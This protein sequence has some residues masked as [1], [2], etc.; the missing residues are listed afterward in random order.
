MTWPTP[1][2][3]NESIQNPQFNFT[4][5]ELKSGQVLLNDFGLPQVASG[6]FASVYR[7]K[8]ESRD[9]AVRCFLKDTPDQQKR[10][11][12]ISEFLNASKLPYV[13][14]FDYLRRGILVSGQ[15]LPILKMEWVQG[16]PLDVHVKNHARESE[17]LRKLA[18][19]IRAMV[20]ALHDC[21]IAHGDLQHGNI[22]ASD[23]AQCKLVDYDG[24]FVPSLRG[25]SS[26]E[27]GHRNYQHPARDNSHFDDRLD[28]FSAWSIITALNCIAEDP[29][30]IDNQGACDES[31]LF[32]QTDYRYPLRSLTFF[33][34][35]SHNS[36]VVRDSA[37]SLRSLLDRKI[38]EIPFL[39]EK[40]VVPQNLPVLASVFTPLP[41]APASVKAPQ[42][43]VEPQSRRQGD[44][45]AEE[46]YPT[47]NA[48]IH[49]ISNPGKAFADSALKK[50]IMA[51]DRGQIRPLAGEHGAVFRFHY[52]DE[53]DVAVKVFFK[54]DKNREER[55]HLLQEFLESEPSEVEKLRPYLVKFD[56]QRN[57]IKV[58]NR[59]YP[60]LVM[61][62]VEGN[63]LFDY[64][65]SVKGQRHY[66]KS[67]GR[68]FKDLMLAIRQAGITHGDINAENV[69]ATIDGLRLIDYDLLRTPVSMQIVATEIGNKNFRH[70]RITSHNPANNDN[71]S[72]WVVY[73]SLSILAIQPE[74]WVQAGVKPGRLLFRQKDLENPAESLTFSL[75]DY[76]YSHAVRAMVAQLK[77][78]AMWDPENVPMLYDGTGGSTH[79]ASA[80]PVVPAPVVTAER[81][82]AGPV[83]KVSSKKFM[84]LRDSDPRAELLVAVAVSALFAL[85]GLALQSWIL[86]GLG[87]CAM[88]ASYAIR[89]PKP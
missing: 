70:P 73:T 74:L 37:R 26:V 33:T 69:M 43:S 41:L 60:I 38:N 7:V 10:Y 57:G 50:S 16:E 4:D 59:Y 75:L 14:T 53:K 34:L 87:I 20:I 51:L 8:C 83:A 28:N 5:P 12:L 31:L 66:L 58:N 85:V 47:L 40:I 46:Y 48:Y 86:V 42:R 13:A 35:E 68:K 44:D 9:I 11:S 29:R 36:Q 88:I 24:M 1:Q 27:L 2:E 80:L 84:I 39:N 65:E 32:K 23:D 56:Y 17:H 45:D 22:L 76:H 63:T 67:L 81:S 89:A 55:Y 62:W 3:Y 15:W 64:V 61:D 19:N 25:Y 6:S 79:S 77:M 49:A 18:E 21:G 71:F 54:P 52:S 72:A 82:A 30:L 78:F